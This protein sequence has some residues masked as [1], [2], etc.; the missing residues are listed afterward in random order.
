MN[1]DHSLRGVRILP[2]SFL[3]SH[4]ISSCVQFTEGSERNNYLSSSIEDL[5]LALIQ[6]ILSILVSLSHA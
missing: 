3:V 2:S 6:S 1:C 5:L 4:Y